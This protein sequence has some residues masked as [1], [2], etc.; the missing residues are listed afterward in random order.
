MIKLWMHAIIQN[1]F[2]RMY[3]ALKLIYNK[4][5]HVTIVMVCIASLDISS[6]SW[7]CDKRHIFC[8]NK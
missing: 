6:P 8:N 5:T 4:L 1:C 7:N 2:V 3:L